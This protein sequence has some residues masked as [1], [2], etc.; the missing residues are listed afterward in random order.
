MAELDDQPPPA[1]APGDPVVIPVETTR[2]GSTRVI[3][4][5]AETAALGQATAAAQGEAEAQ[6]QVGAAQATASEFEAQGHAATAD[7]LEQQAAEREAMAEQQRAIAATA[8][9]NAQE[10]ED[11]VKDFKFHNYWEGRST[12]QRALAIV[13]RFFGGFAGANDSTDA[14]SQAI[15]HDFDKQR[16]EL[17]NLQT[18]AKWKREGVQDLDAHYEKELAALE[19][20]QALALRST[21]EKAQAIA[22]RAKVPEETARNNVLVQKLLTESAMLNAQS[23]QR[24]ERHAT[25]EHTKGEHVVTGG[26]RG[27]FQDARNLRQDINQWGTQNNLTKA[28]AARDKLL[29]VREKIHDPHANGATIASALMEFDTAVRQGTAT[30]ASMNAMM[31]HLGG[32]A[33]N[34]EGLIEQSRSGNLGA[35]KIRALRSAVD[36]AMKASD[37][38]GA[39][40]HD[41]FK[42]RFYGD[43]THQHQKDTIA[44]ESDALFNRWGY[45]SDQKKKR[46]SAAAPGAAPAPAGPPAVTAGTL[47]TAPAPDMRARANQILADPEADNREKA[48]A[49]MWLKSHPAPAAAVP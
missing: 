42:D 20:R 11:R 35:A 41:S 22:I 29:D 1:P 2:S 15:G 24:F 49:A 40:L 46:A 21:A 34:I 47:G 25:Y 16:A 48:S 23:Q 18:L 10:A 44:A 4:T 9:A 13:A 37:A 3:P 26:A 38:E 32:T 14:I 28:T 33:A 43:P 36:A 31:S 39:R 17:S 12:G 6:R 30:S 5:A 27:N 8:R 45:V 19:K 7:Q